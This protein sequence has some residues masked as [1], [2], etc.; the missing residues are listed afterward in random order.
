MMETE[1][2]LE[3]PLTRSGLNNLRSIFR[4]RLSP[5]FFAWDC[6]NPCSSFS[7]NVLL[8]NVLVA[9]MRS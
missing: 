2:G 8:R 9:M 7:M 4:A 5:F 3:C 1:I 6:P